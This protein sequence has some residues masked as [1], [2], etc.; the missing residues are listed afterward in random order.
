MSLS[1][2]TE[3]LEKEKNIVYISRSAPGYPKVFQYFEQKMLF[4]NSLANSTIYDQQC[5]N[6]LGLLCT[7]AC[8]C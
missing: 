3:Q 1:Q 8:H 5:G 6:T 7:S 4:T 2:Q